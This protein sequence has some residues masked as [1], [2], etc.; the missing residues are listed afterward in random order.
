MVCTRLCRYTV[1][2]LQATAR[3]EI[4]PMPGVE[5]DDLDNAQLL[6]EGIIDRA[7][8]KKG[9]MVTISRKKRRLYEAMQ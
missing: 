1:E 3:K 8:L 7:E 5:M 2:R 6:A 4:L 9:A